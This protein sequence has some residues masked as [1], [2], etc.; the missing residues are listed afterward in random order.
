MYPRCS[1]VLLAYKETC[2]ICNKPLLGENL[3]L[4]FI[5]TALSE[6]TT[7][8]EMET[9]GV[10]LNFLN[11]VLWWNIVITGPFPGRTNDKLT[12]TEVFN[13][14]VGEKTKD[15]QCAFIDLFRDWNMYRGFESDIDPKTG[16]PYIASANVYVIHSWQNSCKMVINEINKYASE[17]AEKEGFNKEDFYFFFDL[18]VNNHHK[19][20][21]CPQGWWANDCQSTIEQIGRTVIILDPWDK[22]TAISR[23][24]CLYEIYISKMADVETS[25]RFK[26][27]WDLIRFKILTNPKEFFKILSK[28]NVEKASSYLAADKDDILTAIQERVGFEKFDSVIQHFL[29]QYLMEILLEIV[30]Q[31]MELSHA[32]MKAP[33]SGINP[34]KVNLACGL[35]L[36]CADI[37]QGTGKISEPVTFMKIVLNLTEKFNPDRK[38]IIARA[39]YKIATF[40]VLRGCY[41]EGIP[42]FEKAIA[43]CQECGEDAVEIIQSVFNGLADTYSK[44]KDFGNA[45]RTLLRL[46]TL[47]EEK[48][49]SNADT[50][51]TLISQTLLSLSQMY[52]RFEKFDK[53]EDCL[54]RCLRIH[55]NHDGLPTT[56]EHAHYRLQMLFL[57]LDLSKTDD[58]LTNIV[59]VISMNQR[60]HG[61]NNPGIV[62]NC[63]LPLAEHFYM[64]LQDYD[65]A[66]ELCEKSVGILRNDSTKDD[67]QIA[68]CFQVMGKI[69]YSKCDFEKSK[70]Y[71]EE[72]REVYAKDK[73][74]DFRHL[75]SNCHFSLGEVEEKLKHKEKA[76]LHFKACLEIRETIW[77]KAF[78]A[79]K[80]C[81]D[82]ITQ[83][84]Y[85]IFKYNLK[86]HNF[87]G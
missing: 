48:Y 2:L 67:S 7:T 28:V 41:I 70:K 77:G 3:I 80:E 60:L 9:V 1:V 19:P 11:D 10:S 15:E 14:L 29:G 6:I 73:N 58:A 40:E 25:F 86:S 12:T 54:E 26:A 82:K 23:C 43:I 81:R 74:G 22:P 76:L 85:N 21:N 68:R 57:W 37:L 44:L 36:R 49:A 4:A 17:K 75:L 5:Q 56:P 30:Y 24:W 38:K 84:G 55:N 64:K 83:L 13:L 47:A 62:I 59:D 71:F 63:Y 50:Y 65:K 46:L 32:L 31:A 8:L 52:A 33:G 79:T 87:K 53:A 20:G 34:T 35:L 61:T 66:L 42:A 45:E 69:Y 27:D 18:V 39:N 78:I 72:E 16:K 51:S